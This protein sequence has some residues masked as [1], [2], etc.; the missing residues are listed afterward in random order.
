MTVFD[1]KKQ[2]LA[3]LRALTTAEITVALF[4]RYV[5]N[6]GANVFDYPD[7]LSISQQTIETSGQ[8]GL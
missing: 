4:W 1:A 6:D 8:V 7:A 2:G 5:E 3:L